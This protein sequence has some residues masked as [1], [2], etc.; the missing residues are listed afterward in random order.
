MKKLIALVP[1][2]S[3]KMK[4]LISLVVLVI[5]IYPL[6][7][8]SLPIQR[9]KAVQDIKSLQLPS[10]SSQ[11]V[12]DI[13]SDSQYERTIRTTSFFEKLKAYFASFFAN[14]IE[15]IIDKLSSVSN[16]VKDLGIDPNSITGRFL[17]SLGK[18]IGFTLGA[19]YKIFSFISNF[20]LVLLVVIVGYIIYKFWPNISFRQSL[21]N[22]I[23][24]KSQYKTVSYQKLEGLVQDGDLLQALK[25]LRQILR[26]E[27]CSSFGF[28]QSIT[29]R[30][31]SRNIPKTYKNLH[32][33]LDTKTIFERVVYAGQ[34]NQ[35]T[36]VSQLIDNFLQLNQQYCD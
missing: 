11:I 21:K 20:G 3:N 29:D 5:S 18:I 13:L 36:K 12:Q 16:M 8:N 22:N 25:V 30:E 1:C 34:S 9:N 35:L 31:L 14:K 4:F 17:S 7:G 27:V 32:L 10:N 26:D 6:Q 24:N 23:Q 19:L 33:F 28:V 15:W 2:N